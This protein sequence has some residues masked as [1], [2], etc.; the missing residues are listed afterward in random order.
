MW[1][2]ITRS[3]KWFC[4]C[5]CWVAIFCGLLIIIRGCSLVFWL[6]DD[7]WMTASFSDQLGV[8]TVGRL[9]VDHSL[10]LVGSML[11]TVALFWLV[12]VPSNDV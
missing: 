12:D 4:C 9:V 3:G 2:W 11:F 6:V 8:K 5:S 10:L 1:K 7:D